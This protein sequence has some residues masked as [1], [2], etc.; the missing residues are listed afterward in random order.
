[1]NI[2]HLLSPLMIT[3]SESYCL[4]IAEE[5]M[6]LGNN[7]IILA[8]SLKLRPFP[9]FKEFSFSDRK[10]HNRIKLIIKLR[11]FL[12]DN[13]IDVIHCHSRA[14]SWI[15]VLS[16]KLLK[17]P[18]ISTIHGRQHIHFSSTK[19]NFYGD[20]IIAV[21]NNIQTHLVRELM[22]K[23]ESIAVIPNPFNFS[24]YNSCY[25]QNGENTIL[26]IIGR[27][28]SL[29]GHI[30]KNLIMKTADRLLCRN[31]KLIIRIIGGDIKH[32]GNEALKTIE[33]LNSKYN[34]RIEA[35]GFVY[36]LNDYINESSI[37]IAAG[38]TAIESLYCGK[39]VFALGESYYCGL[40]TEDNIVTAMKSNFGDIADLKSNICEINYDD[41]CSDIQNNISN[42]CYIDF[43]KIKLLLN[44]AYSLDRITN[45]IIEI[46]QSER[47]KKHHKKYIPVLMYHQL[48]DKPIESKH[49]IFVTKKKFEK[50][51]AIL[52]LFGKT[53][54]TFQDYYNY[55]IGA[56]NVKDFPKKP[57]VL[58]F[59]DGYSD[60]Y[61]IIAE[62]SQKFDFKTVHYIIAN[63]NVTYNKW[64]T[65]K[66]EMMLK[67]MDEKQIRDL[68]Q[69]GH[70]IGSH[71]LTHPNLLDAN[72]IQARSEI[73]DSKM[74]IENK[75]NIGVLSI[76][77]PYGIS[78]EAIELSA[79]QAG[80]KIGVAT[81]NGGLHWEDNNF[82][83]FRV[84]I[85]EHQGPLIFAKKIASWYR[86]RY[87]KKRGK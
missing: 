80:Y 41:I 86:K 87:F 12:I 74:Y 33:T 60:T 51:L 17:I 11:K 77:Y 64:D 50:H 36:N 8:D 54:I 5:Q 40:I 85:F 31:P 58:T 39:K 79:R 4:E 7:V 3:G 48:V 71:T 10:F 25:C 23:N 55:K 56:L 15:A 24:K 46:Y 14:C 83:V 21:C 59:D 66:D 32:L 63:D 29:K 44:S 72:I 82:R 75:Y 9:N 35:R 6:K 27:T 49:K 42:T 18:V 68:I 76:C 62:L 61:S 73:E 52:K 67:L 70:E 47:M 65:E 84:Q 1:M 20:K 22:L 69:M 34:N 45:E 13:D 81:D 43:E 16:A 53:T 2:A 30:T 19:F 26:S 57:I 38:R 37:I 28:N 78:D